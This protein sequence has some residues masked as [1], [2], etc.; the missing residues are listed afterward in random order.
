MTHLVI[1]ASESGVLPV[2]PEQVVRKGRLQP[3]KMLLVDTVE[4]RIISDRD[5][6]RSL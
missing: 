4:G 6:K 1:M 3:G 5:L 2:P